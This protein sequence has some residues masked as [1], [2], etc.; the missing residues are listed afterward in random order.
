[1]TNNLNEQMREK[2]HELIRRWLVEDCHEKPAHAE[3]M[4]GAFKLCGRIQFAL[5]NAER[6]GVILGLR[7]A[8][9]KLGDVAHGMLRQEFYNIADKLEKELRT[10]P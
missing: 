2:A 7:M 6:R 10:S 8:A 9:D 3:S 5:Q 4:K 1:M